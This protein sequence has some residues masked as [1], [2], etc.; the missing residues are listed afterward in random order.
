MMPQLIHLPADV[1]LTFSS[2]LL[3]SNGQLQCHVK[4]LDELKN[5]TSQSSRAQEI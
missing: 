2:E 1:A 5:R 3:N 4:F